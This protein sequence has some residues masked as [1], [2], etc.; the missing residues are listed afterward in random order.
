MATTNAERQ[1]AFR[2]RMKSCR[3]Q[4]RRLLPDRIW[5]LDGNWIDDDPHRGIDV[6]LFTLRELVLVSEVEADSTFSDRKEMIFEISADSVPSPENGEWDVGQGL[7]SQ[8]F[9]AW[10]GPAVRKLW[11]DGE[12]VRFR[13]TV[14]ALVDKRKLKAA[15]RKLDEED[16]PFV[17]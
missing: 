8:A 1:K 14:E 12:P 4:L 11:E 2:E 16:N 17:T 15:Q 6:L 7:R 13:V 3:D 9:T 5:L 10:A